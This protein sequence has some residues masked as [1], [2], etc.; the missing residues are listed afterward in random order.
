M[1]KC[2][3]I[4]NNNDAYQVTIGK[5]YEYIEKY[6]RWCN[7]NYYLVTNDGGKLLSIWRKEFESNFT[8]LKEYRERKINVIING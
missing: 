7:T 3:C 6:D 5:A 1:N 2:I 8:T 4:G